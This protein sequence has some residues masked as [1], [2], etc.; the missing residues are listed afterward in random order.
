MPLNIQ[1][2]GYRFYK[3]EPYCYNCNVKN[4]IGESCYKCCDE[5]QN[6][7]KY[8]NLKSPDYIFKN[9]NRD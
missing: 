5:Q 7:K 3:N 1:R 8:P 4:C 9:D 6:R 2:E